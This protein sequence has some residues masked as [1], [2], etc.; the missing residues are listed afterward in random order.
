MEID[1]LHLEIQILNEKNESLQRKLD[2]AAKQL[3]IAKDALIDV[4]TQANCDIGI[5][6]NALDKMDEEKEE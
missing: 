3:Q 2:I 1:K 6:E 5:V 4:R